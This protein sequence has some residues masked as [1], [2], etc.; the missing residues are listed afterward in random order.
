MHSI[1]MP[2]GISFW[3][4]QA[5]SYLID[6]YR[7]EEADPTLL[8][9]CLYMAFWPTVLSGPVCRLYKMLPQFR[10][11]LQPTLDDIAM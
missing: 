2:I 10:A 3:T 4:F 8:E 1:L 5:L 6:I 11:T 7:E 9:F